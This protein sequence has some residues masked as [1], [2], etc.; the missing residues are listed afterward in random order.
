MRRP[1]LCALAVAASGCALGR[2]PAEGGP[3]LVVNNDLHHA[4]DLAYRC[5]D[6]APLR[7]LGTIRPGGSERF[8]LRPAS[9][10]T[11]HLLSQPLGFSDPDRA[12]FAVFPLQGD[13]SLEVTI[14][15][16]GGIVRG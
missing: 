8:V 6:G 7:R 1:L 14:E 4:V 10:S 16:T 11:V 12:P 15:S 3:V 9:C 2:A 5:V 13:R